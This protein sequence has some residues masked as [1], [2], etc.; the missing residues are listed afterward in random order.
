VVGPCYS[1]A[2]KYKASLNVA[3]KDFWSIVLKTGFALNGLR[4]FIPHAFQEVEDF[5]KKSWILRC[6]FEKKDEEFMRSRI[7]HVIAQAYDDLGNVLVAI[8][9]CL[10]SLEK[11]GVA[12]AELQ[13]SLTNIILF[14]DDSISELPLWVRRNSMWN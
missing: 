2:A 5:E 3:V 7:Y 8:Q 4:T 13:Q 6:W 9:I 11:S 12:G 1:D 14:V 10:E